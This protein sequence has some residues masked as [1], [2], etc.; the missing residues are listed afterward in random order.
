[1]E[2]KTKNSLLG[3]EAGNLGT[4]SPIDAV[5]FHRKADFKTLQVLL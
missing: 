2:M 3:S 1:M 4:C 5:T